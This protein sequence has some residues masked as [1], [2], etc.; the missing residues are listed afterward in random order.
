MSKKKREEERRILAEMDA[1]MNA[2]KSEEN[3]VEEKEEKP[4]RCP[5]CKSQMGKGVCPTCGHK[6]Y[7]P[8]DEAMQKKI[9][10][11][12]TVVCLAAFLVIFLI[13]QLK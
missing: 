12:L 1:A 4:L 3:A 10:G 7:I 9:R 2:E 11:I 6:I 5:R 8:M 13:M